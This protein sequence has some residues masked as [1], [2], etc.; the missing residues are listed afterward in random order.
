MTA[1]DR[2]ILIRVKIER[3]RKNLS[4]LEHEIVAFGNKTFYAGTTDPDTKQTELGKHQIWDFDFLA[5]SGDVVHNLRCSLDHL[6]CQLVWAGSGEEPSR[7]VEFPIAKD[8]AT[9]EGDKARKVEGMC[10]K[11][12]KAIDALK[13]YKGGNDALWRIHELDNIDKHRQLFTYSRDCMLTADWLAEYVDIGP[14]GY[15][16]PFNLK[17]RNPQFSTI[18]ASD[19]EVEKDMESEIDEAIRKAHV[20]AGNAVLPTLHQLTDFAWN[21]ILSFKPFL[22]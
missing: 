12:I 8:A 10:P 17:A 1:D 5:A 4:N 7:R 16:G 14:A 3:A 19:N 22:Q 18:G 6:A 20:S 2:I 15:Y 9:Y 11:A 13:P 21:M